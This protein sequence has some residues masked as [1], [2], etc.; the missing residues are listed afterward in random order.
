MPHV[1]AGQLLPIVE[2]KIEESLQWVKMAISL[3]ET[4]L[5][6]KDKYLNTNT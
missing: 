2:T 6:F 3:L 5:G 1:V 4:D